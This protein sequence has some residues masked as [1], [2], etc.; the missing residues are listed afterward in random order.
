VCR[1]RDV[2]QGWT[3]EMR[4][5]GGKEKLLDFIHE[6]V[7]ALELPTNSRFCDLFS[8]TAVVGRHFKKFGFDVT[9]N[10]FLYFAKCL[11]TTRI[12]IN[13]RP[14]FSGLKTNPIT[15]LNDL[16]GASGFFSFSYS[17]DGPCKRQYFSTFNARRIDAIRTQIYQWQVSGEITDIETEY[18]IAALLEAM[19][20]TSN[21]SGTYA[22]FL[23]TWDPRAL[24]SLT[25]EEPMMTPGTGAHF[26]YNQDAVHLAKEVVSE[27]LYL[28]PPYN[29]RQ[30]SSNYFLLDVAA[31]GWFEGEPEVR[32]V[33]GMRDNSNLKSEFCAKSSAFDSLHR[34]VRDAR[35]RY[36][37]LSYNNEGIVPHSQILEMMTSEGNVRVATFTHRRYRAINHD[38]NQKYTT[39]FLFIL[40]KELK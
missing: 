25:I 18:L 7:M 33:T 14:K 32:G 27:V 1:R 5:Y 13:E 37:V 21:V 30:Y 20:R 24:K 36:V 26:V 12:Q 4:Y 38:P 22:A 40:E 16:P 6:E 35:A 17:P 9:A 3:R 28:D 29:S 39:E 15:Y 10:D 23:K 19:N 11:A 34:I 2:V 8:G 31:R